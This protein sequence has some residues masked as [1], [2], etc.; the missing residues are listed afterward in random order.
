MSRENRMLSSALRIAIDEFTCEVFA[1]MRAHSPWKGFYSA[2]ACIGSNSR[3]RLLRLSIRRYG[4]WQRIRI[5]TSSHP[6]SRIGFCFI[7]SQFPLNDSPPSL[8]YICFASLPFKMNPRKSQVAYPDISSRLTCAACIPAST[9]H[10][11]CPYHPARD[12][13]PISRAQAGR[14]CY[15][16]RLQGDYPPPFLVHDIS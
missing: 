14:S 13:S 6:V 4:H 10:Y 8:R 1:A 7:D 3:P 9:T 5:L 11:M 12:H 15:A 16:G 2:Y